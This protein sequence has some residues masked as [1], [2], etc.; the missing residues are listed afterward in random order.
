M[1]FNTT[2][3]FTP[4]K[5][6]CAG[7]CGRQK[8]LTKVNF[9]KC[10]SGVRLESDGYYPVC[11]KCLEYTVLNNN[12]DVKLVGFKELMKEL[13]YPFLSTVLRKSIDEWER[14][15]TTTNDNQMK[16]VGIYLA[17]IGKNVDYKQMRWEDGEIL[18]SDQKVWIK[19]NYKQVMGSEEEVILQAPKED[20]IIMEES[21]EKSSTFVVTKDMVE[22]WG[23]IPDKRM[24]KKYQ[25]EYDRLCDDD[26]G[27]IDSVKELYFKNIS[28][29]KFTAQE[30]L[31]NNNMES[32]VKT[33]K[34][35]QTACE[36]CS[37]NPKNK[38]EREDANRGTYGTFIRMIENERPVFDAEKDL[39]MIDVVKKCIQVFF[40]GHLAEVLGIKNPVKLQYDSVM[41]DNGVDITTYEDL[42][43]VEIEEDDRPKVRARMVKMDALNRFKKRIGG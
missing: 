31:A 17:I 28:I 26:G 33:L 12:G 1:A 10:N 39:G 41:E 40:L 6:T 38:I 34:A 36:A 43:S 29:L 2:N 14:D 8:G 27:F 9:F 25:K 13:D 5:I 32:Y 16:V 11:K 22:F 42:A 35:L 15:Y 18:E 4:P 7:D 23:D 24:Y 20:D 3:P 21:A 19:D 37:I 30:Q